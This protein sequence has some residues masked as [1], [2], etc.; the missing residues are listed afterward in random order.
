[1]KRR[2]LALLMVAVMLFSM[3]VCTAPSNKNNQIIKDGTYKEVAEGNNGD[4]EVTMVVK[5]GG[6]DS[7]KVTKHQESPGIS[8]V[9]IN[10]IPELIVENQAVNVDT[11]S[12]LP[13][14]ALRF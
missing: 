9:A 7:V 2:I 14:Q 6:I 1:M 8:D 11:V 12:G 13:T 10:R 4:V 5:N 3:T